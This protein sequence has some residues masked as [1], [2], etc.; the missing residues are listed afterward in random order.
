MVYHLTNKATPHIIIT[1]PPETSFKIF[2]YLGHVN[3]ACLGATCKSMYGF[4]GE[5]YGTI[6]SSTDERGYTLA[7]DRG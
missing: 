1:V 7:H 2:D 5:K 3:S 6:G 4:H